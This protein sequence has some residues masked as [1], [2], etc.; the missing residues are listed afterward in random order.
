MKHFFNILTID[1]HTLQFIQ[2]ENKN[3]LLS[4]KHDET[5]V[6]EEPIILGEMGT[7]SLADVDVLENDLKALLLRGQTSSD[8]EIYLILPDSQIKSFF[9]PLENIAKEHINANY[10]RFR[11]KKALSQEVQPNHLF[12]FVPLNQ[13]QNSCTFL[14]HAISESFLNQVQKLLENLGWTL[15]SATPTSVNLYNVFDGPKFYPRDRIIIDGGME[16][17]TM[18]FFQKGILKY[19]RV[20]EVAGQHMLKGVCSNQK[21]KLADAR[22]M[23]FEE[24]LLPGSQEELLQSFAK[25]GQVSQVFGNWFRE[26]SLTMQFYQE[27]YPIEEEETIFITGLLARI[28]NIIRIISKLLNKEV[29]LLRLDDKFFQ[30]KKDPEDQWMLV[31]AFGKVIGFTG[32]DRS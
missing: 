10:L 17:T 6:Y 12:D 25:L 13:S 28:P 31:P 2:I 14:V 24:N 21:L 18:S 30:H 5:K 32:E 20:I 1:S 7:Q 22:K 9:I 11:I 23:L 29:H 15:A 19:L 26:V 3:N 16:V 27:N 8:R 4:L